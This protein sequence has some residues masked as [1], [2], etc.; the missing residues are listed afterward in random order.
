MSGEATQIKLI[1]HKNQSFTVEDNG[2]GIPV[3]VN[4]TTG[5]STVDTVFTVLHAG[6]K[7]DD[8]AYKTAGGL[9]GVGASVVNALSSYVDV[10]IKRD[11]KV[12][13]AKYINGG[14]IE[15]P[16]KEIGTT[17][18]TG[19]TVTFKPDPLIFKSTNFNPSIIEE[20]IRES[21]YLFKGLKIIFINE[22]DNSEKIFESTKGIIEYVEFIDDGKSII[23]K[24]AFFSGIS[25]GIEVEV[26]LQYV[27][28]PSEIIVSFANSVKTREGGSH[29]TAF[30][31]SLT[32]C[33]NTCARK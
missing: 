5:I 7:F 1:L 25:G 31:S 20:R 27:S 21:S 4:K 30:K 15:Q 22:I 26:A 8:N 14:H 2:R 23:N 16:L 11:G 12:Y 32:E 3:G 13:E 28:S 9:H 10:V 17:N 6:G 24:P 19:T 18:R 29:E 33:I